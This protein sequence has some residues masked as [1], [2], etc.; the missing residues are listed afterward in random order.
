VIISIHAPKDLFW[1]K[2]GIARLFKGFLLGR[3]VNAKNN[4]ELIAPLLRMPQKPVGSIAG[5]PA[6]LSFFI[7]LLE[8]KLEI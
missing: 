1:Q 2:V 8:S 3:K 4:N 5:E 6:L 7:S